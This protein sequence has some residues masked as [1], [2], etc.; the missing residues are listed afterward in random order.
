[1]QDQEKIYLTP[2]GKQKLQIELEELEEP[3]QGG[4]AKAYDQADG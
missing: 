4:C 1:M 2:E 3:V